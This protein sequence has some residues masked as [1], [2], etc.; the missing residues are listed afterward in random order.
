MYHRAGQ[1]AIK[2][3]S[4]FIDY[5]GEVFVEF[6]SSQARKMF[7][8]YGLYFDGAMFALVA[9]NTLYMKTNSALAAEYESRGLPAFEYSKG[10]KPI[11]MSYHL[12][13][14]EIYDDTEVAAHW[15]HRSWQIAF[16][17]QSKSRRK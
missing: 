1:Q 10:G 4:E 17:N 2:P 7:G 16:E 15:A 3:L 8:G 6:G 5:L 14:E 13:P 11:K 12:A 9:D